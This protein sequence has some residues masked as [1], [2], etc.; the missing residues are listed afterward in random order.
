MT[1]SLPIV[2]ISNLF[3]EA[4][5]YCCFSIRNIFVD[6]CGDA[7]ELTSRLVVVPHENV[8]AFCSKVQT[9]Y[10]HNISDKIT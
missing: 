4:L 8:I 6:S 5:Y 2:F 9:F 10:Q 1:H 7:A 3:C